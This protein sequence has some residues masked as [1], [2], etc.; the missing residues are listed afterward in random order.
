MCVGSNA[1]IPNMIISKDDVGSYKYSKINEKKT[2]EVS[3]I[4]KTESRNHKTSFCFKNR[5]DK[6]M[7]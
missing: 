5:K 6:D 7:N 2:P 3:I 1:F 4:E